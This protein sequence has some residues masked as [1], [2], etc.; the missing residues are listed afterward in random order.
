MNK[1]IDLSGLSEFL[2]KCKELFV[3]KKDAPQPL[4][5]EGSVDPNDYYFTP[6]DGQPSYEEAEQAFM[7]GIPVILKFVSG[8][9]NTV[10][11]INHCDDGGSY[12]ITL[13]GLFFDV[14]NNPSWVRWFKIPLS[15][16]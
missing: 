4:I 8:A 15:N 7:E 1:L 16:I 6:L 9:P 2:K 5:V 3:L 10:L 11:I 13:T 14:N 12:G